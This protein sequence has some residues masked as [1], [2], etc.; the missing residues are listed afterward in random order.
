MSCGNPGVPGT[1]SRGPRPVRG[2]DTV[3]LGLASALRPALVTQH[4][5]YALSIFG[6]LTYFGVNDTP[7]RCEYIGR[8]FPFVSG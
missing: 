7:V 6:V 1:G 8:A 4:V 2:W 3:A 5:P